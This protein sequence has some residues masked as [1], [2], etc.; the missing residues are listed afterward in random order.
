MT[1]AA[2]VKESVLAYA[3]RRAHRP[4]AVIP[5]ALPPWW[6][7]LRQRVA[8]PLFAGLAAVTAILLFI[9]VISLQATVTDLESQAQALQQALEQRDALLAVLPEG[10]SLPITGTEVQP[11]AAGQ[12]VVGVDGRTAVLFVSDLQTLT[13]EQTYQLWLIGDSGPVSEGLFRVDAEGTGILEVEAEAA[14][15][16]YTAIGVSVEPE[17]G[18][19]QPTGDIVML[20]EVVLPGRDS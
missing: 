4:A 18:S 12:L 19:P 15:F 13:S 2:P 9:W 3:R 11:D 20:G 17:G 14:V 7:R 10:R 1:P 5:V 6:Q 8:L 16:S